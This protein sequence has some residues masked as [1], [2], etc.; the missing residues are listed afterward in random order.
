M[1]A[2]DP[3]ASR[4]SVSA[5]KGGQ[6]VL[7]CVSLR[8]VRQVYIGLSD[9]VFGDDILKVGVRNFTLH[10]VEGPCD[11]RG[12]VRQGQG[13][14]RLLPFWESQARTADVTRGLG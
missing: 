14:T 4:W 7:P 5:L 1:Q 13:G 6:W 2:P 10:C 9:L 3:H 12:G 11:K 8:G